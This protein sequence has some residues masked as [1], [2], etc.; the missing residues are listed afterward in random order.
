[1]HFPSTGA[2]VCALRAAH[3]FLCCGLASAAGDYLAPRLGLGNVLTVLE[4]VRPSDQS[5]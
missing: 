3:K 1:M 5:C 4:E 2:A